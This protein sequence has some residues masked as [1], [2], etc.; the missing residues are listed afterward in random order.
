MLSIYLNYILQ[1]YCYSRISE[2]VYH[3]MCF[4]LLLLGLQGLLDT[5][6]FQ[7]Y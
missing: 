7:S 2:R 6:S 5:L 3:Q 4:A 1:S